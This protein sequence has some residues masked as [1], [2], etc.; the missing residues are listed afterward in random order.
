MKN[1]VYCSCKFKVFINVKIEKFSKIKFVPAPFLKHKKS[2]SQ[3]WRSTWLWN[4]IWVHKNLQ[5]C[6][7]PHLYCDSLTHQEK[8]RYRKPWSSWFNAGLHKTVS[9]FKDCSHFSF[10]F[11][12]LLCFHITLIGVIW[13]SA[14]FSLLPT[15]FKEVIKCFCWCLDWHKPFILLKFLWPVSC[16]LV[17]RLSSLQQPYPWPVT[18]NWFILDCSEAS[19]ALSQL[20]PYENSA[21]RSS[22]P[23][24]FSCSLFPSQTSQRLNFL[25]HCS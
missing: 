20:A 15:N 5:T 10:L 18:T 13:L 8:F 3:P 2:G 21:K 9:A 19:G 7:S 17:P 4:F 1:C 12:R 16:Y 23:I 24:I 25:P 11:K 22:I 14:F 6:R